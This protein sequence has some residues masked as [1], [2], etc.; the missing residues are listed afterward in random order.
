MKGIVVLASAWASS[1]AAQDIVNGAE[2]SAYP[3]AVS[4][5]AEIGGYTMSMCTGSLITPKVVLTAAHCS[6]DIPLEYVVALGRIF[7]GPSIT[8]PD[9][10]SGLVDAVIH[11]DY[12]ELSSGGYSPGGGTY[13]S[14]GQYDVALVE[15]AEPVEGVRPVWFQ[16]EALDDLAEGASV[17]SVGFGVTSS[18]SDDAGVK[19]MAELVVDELSDMFVVSRSTA[20]PNGANVCSGDSGGPQ[21]YEGGDV[22]VQW[23]VHSWADA[24][25]NYYSGST[26]TDVVAEWILD[27]LETIHGTRDRCEMWGVYGDG[28]CDEDCDEPDPDCEDSIAGLDTGATDD[29]PGSDM[30]TG[31]DLM[32]TGFDLDGQSDAGE[33]EDASDGKGCTC[34]VSASS[35]DAW[36][37]LMLVAGVVARRR[38]D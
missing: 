15:L 32:D 20:N 10:T 37:A 23:A 21:Y 25:C 31:F 36:F 6:S 24:S 8:A 34:A 27:E 3:A 4:L 17:T 14:L 28:D 5:G 22:P 1:A 26:R 7:F 29:L 18:S 12:V 35:P 16:T 11:P 2:T 30:D 33:G 9:Q 38:F 19:R 13:D